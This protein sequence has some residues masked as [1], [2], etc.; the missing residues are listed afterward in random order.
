[1]HKR[2]NI[3][4]Y[5]LT[6]CPHCKAIATMLDEKEFQYKRINVDVLEEEEKKKMIM[7]VRKVNRRGSFPTTVIDGKVVVGYKEEELKEALGI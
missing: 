6:T 4:L 5:A 2:K 1:M 7:E 3:T